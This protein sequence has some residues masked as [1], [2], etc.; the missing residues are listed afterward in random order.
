MGSNCPSHNAQPLGAKFPV[1][2]LISATNGFDMGSLSQFCDGKI[3]CKAMMKFSTRYGDMFSCGWLPPVGNMH[4]GFMEESEVELNSFTPL[5][6]AH[7]FPLAVGAD[8]A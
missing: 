6:V 4:A 3:P 5:N 1:K 8:G 2:I 7:V